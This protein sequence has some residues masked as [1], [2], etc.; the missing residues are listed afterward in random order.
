[1]KAIRISIRILLGII[2]LFM[3]VTL[4]STRYLHRLSNTAILAPPYEVSAEAR[5]LHDTLLI[6]D[7]HIDSAVHLVDFSAPQPHGH[8]GRDRL[9]A[10]NLS[11][12]TLSLP[13][14]VN[15]GNW[16][17]VNGMA[18][19]GIVNGQPAETWFSNYRRG[20]YFIDHIEK[21]V[22]VNPER[23]FVIRDRGD[24]QA[25]IDGRTRGNERMLGILIAVEGIHILDGDIG[26]LVPL[27]DRGV[28]MISLTHGFDNEAAGSSTGGEQGGLT[29]YGRA[30][31]EVMERERVIL[32][33][34]HLSDRAAREALD[35]VSMPVVVSHTGVRGTCDKSRNIPDDIIRRVAET[36]GVIGVGLFRSVLCGDDIVAIVRVIDYIR[37]R[38]GIE[39]IALGSDYDGAVR[40]IFDVGGLPLLTDALLDAGYSDAEIRMI[41]GGNTVRVLEQALPPG[42]PP[43]Y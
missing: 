29:A 8:I 30:V 31:L 43:D 37:D 13:T 1:M 10:G 17:G 20:G 14:E 38:V 19:G 3:V 22:A 40:V 36:G 18:I 16:R 24:V 39:H 25:L 34:A 41:M 7:L 26:N 23:M 5:R 35:I 6:A 12:M 21:I 27:I 4:V 9:A 28:R 33:L 2:V 15:V 11:L 32:D 42:D